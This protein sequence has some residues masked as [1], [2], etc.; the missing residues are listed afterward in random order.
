[1]QKINTLISKDNKNTKLKSYYGKALNN[2][3]FKD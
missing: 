2:K 3:N 1:M